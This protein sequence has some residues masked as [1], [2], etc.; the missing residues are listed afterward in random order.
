[1]FECLIGYPPFCSETPHETYKKI[2]NWRNHLIIPDDVHLSREAEDLIRR[3]I[4]SPDQRLNVQQIRKHPFFYGVDWDSIRGID[5]PFVPHLRSITDT[6]Y[7]PTEELTQVPDEPVG[8]DKGTTNKDL[9]FLGYVLQQV[10]SFDFAD[11]F[12]WQFP[13][14]T[15]KR[16][17]ISSHAF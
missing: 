2:V 10:W 4:T 11:D 3:L 9:A 5:A 17:T 1:M 15:F 7:F 12:A 8:A 6:S 14:Y 16:F 13:R